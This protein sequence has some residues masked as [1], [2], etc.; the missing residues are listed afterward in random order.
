MRA[1]LPQSFWLESLRSCEETGYIRRETDEKRRATAILCLIRDTLQDGDARGHLGGAKLSL[2]GPG[3]PKCE[4]GVALRRCCTNDVLMRRAEV[5]SARVGKVTSI[6]CGD[7]RTTRSNGEGRSEEDPVGEAR[8][9]N[10]ANRWVPEA[11]SQFM[12]NRRTWWRIS[13]EDVKLQDRDESTEFCEHATKYS[14]DGWV[15]RTS[16]APVYTIRQTWRKG[17]VLQCLLRGY[18]SQ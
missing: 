6:L 7:G 8:D 18:L 17:K 5:P 9:M 10:L 12:T 16:G 11:R 13:I 3:H 14:G 4:I 1:Q 15:S 2:K